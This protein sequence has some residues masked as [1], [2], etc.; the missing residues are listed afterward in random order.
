MN[1]MVNAG[2]SDRAHKS[3]L[4]FLQ[5]PAAILKSAKPGRL[6]L[7]RDDERL[8]AP[9]ADVAALARAGLVLRSES[10]IA[11]SEKGQTLADQLRQ[12]PGLE[13][14]DMSDENAV[15]PFL[16]LS[17]DN[18]SPLAALQARTRQS[19]SPFLAQPEFDAGERLRS[20]F[21]RALLAPRISANW[22]AAVSAGRRSGDIN[23]VEE[24]S[25]SA[26]A[27]RQRFEAAL[28]CLGPD[29]SGAAADICCFLKGFEQVEIERK[30]PK[31]SAKFMLKAALAVLAL[32]YWPKSSRSQSI[33]RWGSVDYRPEINAQR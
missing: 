20:D 33:R 28:A 1:D 10:R 11:L 16:V 19:G 13:L 30:W 5:K 8:D 32:H 23:G 31:R 2:A 26:F 7:A 4:L 25:A 12:R 29:L 3:V 22:T 24:L 14:R 18:E 27:A 15:T 17:N 9:V 6:I 21:T